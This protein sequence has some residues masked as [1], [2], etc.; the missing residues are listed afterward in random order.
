[1]EKRFENF[2]FLILKAGKLIQRIKNLEVKQYDLKAVHVMC[3]YYLYNSEK[4]LTSSELVKLT[5]EDKAA[6]SRAIATLTEK[7]YVLYDNKYQSLIKLTP[8][9]IELA[10][11][12]EEKAN[13]AVL[14]VGSI[15]QDK[16]REDFYRILKNLTS[17]LS[18]YHDSLENNK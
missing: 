13:K 3:I 4:G 6:I 14:D 11:V 9:G 7:K 5:Y 15:L 18:D 12:V 10:K 8:K 17:K 2:T 16:E 1:M